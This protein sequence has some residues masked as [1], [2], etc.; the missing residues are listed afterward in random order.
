ME[1]AG[2]PECKPNKT[3]TIFHT[4]AKSG[5]VRVCQMFTKYELDFNEDTPKCFY[6]QNN[7]GFVGDM[8]GANF[9][10]YLVCGKWTA[11]I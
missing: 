3:N 8:D 5:L 11:L 10:L 4:R 6:L 7:L 9:V 2:D 1:I